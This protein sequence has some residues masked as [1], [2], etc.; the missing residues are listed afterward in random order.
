MEYIIVRTYGNGKHVNSIYPLWF[1]WL[2]QAERICNELNETN[3]D[4]DKWIVMPITKYIGK[5]H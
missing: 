2:S 5:I 4:S 1:D 3:Y